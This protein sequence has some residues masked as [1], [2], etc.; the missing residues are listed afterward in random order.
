M[1]LEGR[2]ALVTGAGSGIGRAIALLFA[3]EGA[4]VVVN[5][6]NLAAA[7]E[8]VSQMTAAGQGLVPAMAVKADVASSDEVKAMFAEIEARH[9]TLDILVNNAGIAETDSVK[10]AEITRKG[11]ARI[12][13]M[14]MG[15]KTQTH[16]DITLELGDED[17][18]RMIAVH[19]NGTFFCTRE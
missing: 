7:Q 5:D 16:W 15:G 8:T 12:G 14:M 1:K 10:G 11:E 6:I 4:Q 3:Q 9:G 17:W 18:H 19:L 13:E 2:I